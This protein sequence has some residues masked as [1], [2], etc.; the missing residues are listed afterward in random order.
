MKA[1]PL[2]I[3]LI[4]LTCASFTRG[5]ASDHAHSEH[6]KSNNSQLK[7]DHGKKWAT[8]L[9]LRQSME[10]ISQLM[11]NHLSLIH[12]GKM[13]DSAYKKLG[14]QLKTQTNNIFKNCGRDFLKR[15][16]TFVD[17]RV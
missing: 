9:P 17:P 16:G 4:F 10:E 7:L 13:S 3:T 5:F 8:D 12:N 2:K 1:I 15:N 11:N 14:Q 6:S